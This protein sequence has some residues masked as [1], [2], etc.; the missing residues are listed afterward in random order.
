V[1]LR[2]PEVRKS[3]LQQQYKTLDFIAAWSREPKRK[4]YKIIFKNPVAWHY[5]DCTE[6]G[7]G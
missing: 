2:F 7:R 4:C 6:I 3:R 5:E 1:Y